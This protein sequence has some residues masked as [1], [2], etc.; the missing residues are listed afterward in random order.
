MAAVVPPTPAAELGRLAQPPADPF[1]GRQRPATAR[2][3]LHGVSAQ[4]AER[5]LGALE[6]T[7]AA[8]DLPVPSLVAA[9]PTLPDDVRRV[10]V[11]FSSTDSELTIELSKLDAF[12]PGAV[13]MV[14]YVVAELVGHPE[15]APLLV[16]D[17]ADEAAI[18]AAHG[19]RH[20][21]LA[22]V[23]AAIV[24]RPLWPHV[25][26]PAIIG[27]AIGVAAPILRTAPMPA[28]YA[29]AVLAKRRAEYRLPRR[30]RGRAMVTDHVF[31]LAEHPFESTVDFSAN[32]LVTAIPGGLAV[33]SGLE[34]GSVS[35]TM[36]VVEAPPE[37]DLSLWHEV[38]EISWHAPAGGAV[39][40][41][42]SGQRNLAPP[43]PGDYRALVSAR[44]RGEDR[45]YY[46]LVI[47]PSPAA[48]PLVHKHSD[49]LGYVLRGEP[50]P[51]LVVAPD[52]VYHWVESSMLRDAATIT[53]VPGRSSA[54][55]LRAF[56]ADPAKPL[57]LLEFQDRDYQ[58]IDPWVCVL[59]RPDGV[60]AVEFNGWQ[61]SNQPVLRGL[62]STGRAASMFWNVNGTRRLSVAR[63]GTV[64]ASFDLRPEATDSPEV[65]ALLA[66]VDL[67]DPYHLS[68]KGLLAATR[69]TGIT[70][71]PD[72]LRHIAAADVGYAI[73]PLLPE[74]YTE[75]LLADGTRRWP[76]HGPLGADTDLL[77]ALP[78]DRLRELAWWAAAF[79]VDHSEISDHPEAV[80]SLAACALTPEAELL[81]RR[82]GLFE[83]Q[84]HQLW[85]ALHN[86]TNPDPL[87]A[88]IGALNAA[89]Y[90][91]AGHAADLLAQAR[92][93]VGTP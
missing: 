89:R 59:D 10:G 78:A 42:D 62:S 21:A 1:P 2:N 38:V 91:V 13:D 6:L 92:A 34:S 9:L 20:L 51:P 86:A 22:V 7:V 5:L 40:S 80:A 77:A 61:G 84:H 55:V 4:T 30:G 67:D 57:P 60:I 49:R 50:E 23:A 46:E 81:A 68:A 17:G 47:W 53:F 8:L 39:V 41:G 43:W 85:M 24:L 90:A 54:D 33:R 28:G 48:E 64:L 37:P 15:V 70:L 63:D 74:L 16:G 65:L 11:A 36:R 83:G 32:G 14:T 69:F 31:T 45:E 25:T 56:G 26:A 76:G 52:A 82:S 75:Q 58:N 73:L 79:A 72:D 44:D 35:F 93:Q 87:G 19:S 66:D 18:A 3:R 12:V 71:T 88:A 29:D 27:A